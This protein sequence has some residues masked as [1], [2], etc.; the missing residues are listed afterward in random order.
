M[1][2]LRQVDIGFAS[3]ARSQK[4][5]L[6]AFFCFTCY[7]EPATIARQAGESLVGPDARHRKKL[8]SKWTAAF[9][10]APAAG[11]EPAT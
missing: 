2:W 3:S 5:M 7:T 6:R 10:M 11:L 8:L 4:K 1:P 9:F